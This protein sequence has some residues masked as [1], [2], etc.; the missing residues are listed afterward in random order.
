VSVSSGRMRAIYRKE[1]REYR[2]NGSI[3]W[4]MAILPLIFLIQPLIQVFAVPASASGQ[5]AGHRAVDHQVTGADHRPEFRDAPTPARRQS[6]PAISERH[7]YRKTP[8]FDRI[9]KFNVRI[10]RPTTRH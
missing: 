2:R 3:V 9:L 6:G 1:L 10:E 8:L 5:L 4:A 7:L